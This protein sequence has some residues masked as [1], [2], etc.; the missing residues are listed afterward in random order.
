LKENRL[1]FTHTWSHFSL[2]D[3]EA[4]HGLH[5]FSALEI[6]ETQV[7]HSS[8]YWCPCQCWLSLSQEVPRFQLPSQAP[9][10][11]QSWNSVTKW[12]S[13]S[14]DMWHLSSMA[15]IPLKLCNV[16]V[17]LWIH[18]S[19][20]L[21]HSHSQQKYKRSDAWGIV[22]DLFLSLVV[23]SDADSVGVKMI[24]ALTWFLFLFNWCIF[25]SLLTSLPHDG[26]FWDPTSL[27]K[28]IPYIF[29]S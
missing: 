10:T 26:L 16:H 13:S 17:S 28:M 24:L 19:H 6:S 20:K 3:V 27:N 11:D 18:L 21:S 1:P 23:S 22:V 5:T 15:E 4:D 7:L 12:V 25:M 2:V 29:C 14:G 8:P 9:I